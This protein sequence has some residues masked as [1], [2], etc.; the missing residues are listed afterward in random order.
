MRRRIS[1]VRP[2]SPRVSRGVRLWVERGS[3]AYSAV[4]QPAVWFSI[5]RGTLSSTLT[6]QRMRVR[7]TSMSTEPS[8]YST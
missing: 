6:L 3:K 2:P 7:P 8:A 1:W 4:N 5:Q